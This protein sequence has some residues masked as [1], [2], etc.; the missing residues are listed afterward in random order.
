MQ[1]AAKLRLRRALVWLCRI[2]AGGAFI[3]SGWAKSIDPWGFLIKVNEY[4]SVWGFEVPRELVL[5]GS[6]GLSCI[7]FLIG[8]LLITGCLKR[9]AAAGAAALMLFML[10]L[11]L[12]IALKNPVSDCGCFGDFIIV[13]NW[14]TFW[15]NVVLTSA[16]AYLLYAGRTVR[17]FFPAPIQWLVV[18]VSLAFPMLL[19]FAGYHMQPL[20]DF[21]PYKTGT[22][23]FADDGE[24]ASQQVYVYE[25]NG[26]SAEFTLDNIPDST[27]TF[28]DVVDKNSDSDAVHGFEVRD[29]DGENVL[30]YLNPL[31]GAVLYLVV[32]EPDVQFLSRSHYVN[33]LYEYAASHDVRMVGI[34]GATGDRMDE[35]IALTRPH[36]PVYS[37]ENTAL[38]QLARGD[39]ALVYTVGGV[40]EWKRNLSG[41]DTRLPSDTS[42]VNALDEIH[43]ID[44][45]RVH[46]FLAGCYLAAMIVIY[47]LGL[48]PRMLRALGRLSHLI[49]DRH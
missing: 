38:Q 30:P 31:E 12:Y 26:T 25:K 16:V 1:L 34:V 33:R 27:W 47:L 13:S 10:P 28:V 48:S 24:D 36:F 18:A 39:A 17:G 49:G 44:D 37:A 45:G 14:L 46:L 5:T 8:V 6:V 7:E 3:V 42:G 32:P 9:A 21:R 22:V 11:T 4:L 43:H 41:M 40:V 2:V 19:A 29:A 35:W 20:V 23:L 15:K